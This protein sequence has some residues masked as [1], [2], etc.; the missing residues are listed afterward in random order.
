MKSRPKIP[1]TPINEELISMI[2]RENELLLAN[3]SHVY[4]N[5]DASRKKTKQPPQKSPEEIKSPQ[6]QIESNSQPGSGNKMKGEE[7]KEEVHNKSLQEDNK[8]NEEYEEEYEEDESLNASKKEVKAIQEV[9]KEVEDVKSVVAV[10]KQESDHE[11]DKKVVLGENGEKKLTT[12][13]EFKLAFKTR[14]KIVRTPPDQEK[15]FSK[16]TESPYSKYYKEPI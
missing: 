16:L 2:K 14:T 4:K 3:A 7:N 12:T 11:E 8:N 9:K 1:R 15:R 5:E 13:Q 6:K 10:I